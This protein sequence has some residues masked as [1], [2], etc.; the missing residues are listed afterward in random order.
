[1]SIATFEFKEVRLHTPLEN[2]CNA[3]GI[4]Q[5][6]ILAI[7]SELNP[8]SVF[9]NS[10]FKTGSLETAV[11]LLVAIISEAESLRWREGE[12]AA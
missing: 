6:Q 11:A 1:M 8:T 2:L 7:D 3:I 5:S 4:I 10:Y 12:V 9:G